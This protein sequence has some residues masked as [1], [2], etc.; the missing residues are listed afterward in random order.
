[1][2][3]FIRTLGEFPIPGVIAKAMVEG[4]R[5]N[6]ESLAIANKQALEG[7]Q[8]VLTRQGEILESAVDDAKAAFAE[9]AAAGGPEDLAAKQA[10]LLQRALEHALEEMRILGETVIQS[11]ADAF[12][13]VRTRI[14]ESLDEIRALAQ[15]VK[16]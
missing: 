2:D 15:S 8:A 16:Q 1:M 10:E 5:R 7:Y 9:L 4:N 13:T 14:T 12:E 6:I 11:N 3:R